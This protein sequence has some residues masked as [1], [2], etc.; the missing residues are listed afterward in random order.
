ML[1]CVLFALGRA[2]PADRGA[3]FEHRANRGL[4]RTRAPRGDLAGRRA[5]VRAILIEANALD[6]VRYAWLRE[7]RIRARDARLRAAEAFL[8]APYER[9]VHVAANV[10]MAGNHF[11]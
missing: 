11:S 7:T 3:R 4:V 5:D 10:R 9:I 8:D 1:A 2:K 6:E